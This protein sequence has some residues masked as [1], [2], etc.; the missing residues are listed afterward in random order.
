MAERFPAA[1]E[2][3]T[4]KSEVKCPLCPRVYETS[5]SAKWHLRQN[6]KG[7]PE[8]EKLLKALTKDVCVYCG[9][10][11]SDLLRHKK[12]CS[13]N[14]KNRE[15]EQQQLQ[16]LVPARVQP[17]PP[18][19]QP[20]PHPYEKLSNAEMVDEFADRLVHRWKLDAKGTVPDYERVL[21][22]FIR[23]ETSKDPDFMAFHWFVVG[24]HEKRDPRFK[25]ISKLQDYFQA[26]V[27]D[28]GQKTVDRMTTVYSHLHRWID[29][30]INEQLAD[31]LS[32]HRQRGVEA[33]E[34][35]AVARRSGAFKPGQGRKVK[36]DTVTKHLD[37]EI[38]RE[39]LRFFL[40]SPLLRQTMEAFS[41]RAYVHKGCRDPKCTDSRCMLGIKERQDAQNFLALAIFL[42]NFG[43]RLEVV[44][45]VTL[46]ALRG[47][48][49][50]LD[51]CPYCKG[52][53]IYA[54]HKKL[55]HR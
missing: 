10:E 44:M 40:D 51:V 15:Q 3:G 1:A 23:H 41:S 27:S 55:C 42:S 4:R 9:K 37:V 18:T 49:H 7:Y 54:E 36:R 22:Q 50:A 20:P 30:E 12:T 8:L 31:P 25:P 45:N 6:H 26:L 13:Q 29:E 14:P 11:K 35:R 32:L 28:Q 48:A 5:K 33:K 24:T 46:G 2:E 16:S 19:Q 47:A 34:A 52:K 21:K 43:L 39:V 53:H 38:V 17:P